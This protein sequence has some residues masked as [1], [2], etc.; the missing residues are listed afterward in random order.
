MKNLL[1]GILIVGLSSSIAMAQTAE[2]EKDTA[3][4]SMEWEQAL[5][6]MELTLEKIEIPRIDVDSL[7]EEVRKVMPSKEEIE[8]YKDVVQEVIHE[9]KKIDLSELEIAIKNLNLE[10]Q[11][12][13]GK[14]NNDPGKDLEKEKPKSRKI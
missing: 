12:I 3:T 1:L 5:D 4:I 10:L 13:F 14:I 7:V 11:D 9:F 2:P 8:E 6:E